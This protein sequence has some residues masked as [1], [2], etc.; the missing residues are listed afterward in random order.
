MTRHHLAQH[1]HR[2]GPAADPVVLVSGV[3]ALDLGG[4][5]LA[6]TAFGAEY[7][8]LRGD[9]VHGA[10][11]VVVALSQRR[12]RASTA[13]ANSAATASGALAASCSANS[14]DAAR[15]GCA[16]P[17]SRPRTSAAS[18][19]VGQRGPLF[20]QPV[21]DGDELGTLGQPACRCTR[22][23]CA[24]I[25]VSFFIANAATL[26]CVSQSTLGLGA[27]RDRLERVRRARRRRR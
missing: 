19:L 18:L 2:A 1:L 5:E 6:L 16:S 21:G 15:R 27:G 13:S 3:L 26:R 17:A 24:E 10:R 4:V 12:S 22:V 7:R 23:A 25:S 20:G 9:L 11:D 8:E 14:I